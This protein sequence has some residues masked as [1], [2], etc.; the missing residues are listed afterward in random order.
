MIFDVNNLPQERKVCFGYYLNVQHIVPFIVGMMFLLGGL[1]MAFTGLSIDPPGSYILLGV[2]G[3]IASIALIV[4]LLV[5]AKMSFYPKMVKHG[6][7]LFV[8]VVH[9]GED[10][11]LLHGTVDGREISYKVN[12]PAR[13]SK[14]YGKYTYIPAFY[15]NERLMPD[16]KN[17]PDYGSID[18]PSKGENTPINVVKENVNMAAKAAND[19]NVNTQYTKNQLEDSFR[20]RYISFI[21]SNFVMSGLLLIFLGRKLTDTILVLINGG[22]FDPFE[23]LLPTIVTIY[24]VYALLLSILTLGAFAKYTT[25]YKKGERVVA[26]VNFYSSRHHYKSHNKFLSPF[27]QNVKGGTIIEFT[28]SNHTGESCSGAYSFN[29]AY[30]ND[31]KDETSLPAIV[32][33]NKVYPNWAGIVRHIEL[34]DEELRQQREGQ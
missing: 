26:S 27:N 13:F 28:Y 34:R 19:A 30:Y 17:I 2:G 12:M 9:V 7:R 29:P 20:G 3:T 5:I 31:L 22:A 25:A 33:K 4:F 1:F 14:L 23:M 21:C 16:W 6:T 32:Y 15:H 11:M 10:S 8:E 24:I 18:A